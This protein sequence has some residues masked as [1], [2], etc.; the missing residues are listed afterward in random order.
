[1]HRPFYLTAL[2]LRQDR[3]ADPVV[4]I[5]V[6]LGVWRRAED[7]WHVRGAV[8]DACGLDPARVMVHLTHTHAGPSTNSLDHGAAGGELVPGYV[9]LL[10]EAAVAASA[11]AV[12]SCAPSTLTVAA[13]TSA[14]AACR[15]LPVGTRYAVGFNPDAPAD[16]TLLVARVASAEGQVLATLVNYACHPTT[17][18]WQN[19][20][21]SPDLVGGIREVI[22]GGTAGAPCLFLQGAA[23]DLAPREQYTGDTELADR[24]GRAIGH[25]AL[26][27]LLTLPPPSR[28]LALEP[29][30]E[31]GAP[32]APHTGVLAVD[33]SYGPYGAG[34]VGPARAS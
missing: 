31:S 5:S 33:D 13:G 14:V 6:D 12:G 10:R 29:V 23:G 17:L 16:D 2:A 7:E 28:G 34:G 26:G 24:H 25:A 11:E 30:V 9:D 27:A 21:L 3:D 19:T 8:L 4:L 1:M 32:L 22:E 18:A 15:D 20:A